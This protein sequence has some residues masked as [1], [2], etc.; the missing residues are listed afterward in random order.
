LPSDFISCHPFNKPQDQR[1]T[2]CVWQG[3]YCVQDLDSLT[4]KIVPPLKVIHQFFCRARISVKI[5]SMI[6][7]DLDQPSTR[8]ISVSERVKVL[9]GREKYVLQNV[10]HFIAGRRASSTP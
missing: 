1:F 9:K 7:G 4:V 8:C 5:C 2:I 3:F 10:L 6:P